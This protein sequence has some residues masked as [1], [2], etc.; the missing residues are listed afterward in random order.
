LKRTGPPK[1]SPFKRGNYPHPPIRRCLERRFW[2]K[3]AIGSGC[4]NWTAATRSD[5]RG[6]IFVSP[7]KP[8]MSAHRAS[9]MLV[10]GDLRDDMCVLHECD[11]PL[12]VRPSHLRLG[13]QARLREL[14]RRHGDEVTLV[15]AH[16]PWE[17]AGVAAG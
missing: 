2:A 5:G 10:F 16:D 1:R 11:N 12:C 6:L 13:T 4:W 14:A 3:V 8:R 7:G 15:S 17:L 9:W